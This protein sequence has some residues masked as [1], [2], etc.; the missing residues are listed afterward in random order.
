[1]ILM[2]LY[3]CGDA[4]FNHEDYLYNEYVIKKWN[5]F[6]KDEDIVLILGDFADSSET[7]LDIIPQLNG[8]IEFI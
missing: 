5:S 8:R 6:I 1:M 3:I 2:E 4:K 7:L